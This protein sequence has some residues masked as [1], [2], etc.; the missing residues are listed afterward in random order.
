MKF[1][2]LSLFFFCLTFVLL[3]P[4]TYAQ[5]TVRPYVLAGYLDGSL[6]DRLSEIKTKLTENGFEIVG[7]YTIEQNAVV[8]AITNDELKKTAVL[9]EFGGYGVAQRVALT[10]KEKKLQL[11]YT[12]PVYFGNAY[13]MKNL[14]GI[15]DRLKKGLGFEKEFGSEDG[16]TSEEL[17]EYHYMVTMPYFEDHNTLAEYSSY[18]EAVAAVEKGLAA[19]KHGASKIYRIDIPG[20]DETVFGVAIEKGD[21]ADLNVIDKCDLTETSHTAYVPYEMLVSGNKIYAPHGK[22]RIALHFPD[23]SMGTFMK[24]SG[25]PGDIEDVLTAVV[26]SK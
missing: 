16:L 1:P 22:F 12:N 11:S 18:M 20:K 2:T 3:P 14:D 19:H 26:K 15:Y 24:I 8:L 13:K 9:S 23:L 6:T 10:K 17:Q 21:G 4:A 5:Q 7:E 25:A